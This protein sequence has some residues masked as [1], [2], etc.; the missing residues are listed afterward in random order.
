MGFKLISEDGTDMS[1][2]MH[3]EETEDG[4]IGLQYFQFIK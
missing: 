3:I 1:F 4:K 2:I